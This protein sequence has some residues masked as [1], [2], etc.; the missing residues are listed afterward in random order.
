M[1]SSNSN[2]V[3]SETKEDFKISWNLFKENWKAFLS[4]IF[5]AGV[6]L[7]IVAT[8][9]SIIAFFYPNFFIPVFTRLFS[10]ALTRLI[11][12]LS[13]FIIILIGVFVFFAFLSC[14]YGLAY[15]IMSS[16]DMFAEFKGSFT[17]FRR[18]WW[19]YSILTF[20]IS[21]GIF[22]LA[23]GGPFFAPEQGAPLPGILMHPP[24]I[25]FDPSIE[26]TKFIITEILKSTLYFCWF[27]IFINT[28]PSIT[29][30][31]HKS[32]NKKSQFNE[33][34]NSF[35]ESFNIFH[36]K[37]KRLFCTWGLFFIIF[38]IP[39][40]TLI[41]TA[42]IIYNPLN[43]S[44]W[45]IIFKISIQMLWIF[46]I[47]VGTPMMALISTRIFNSIEFEAQINNNKNLKNKKI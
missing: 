16:G 26:M 42:N 35:S 46:F 2:K 30:R 12:F 34:K 13:S 20:I 4:T 15:D 41:I 45:L 32:N 25:G 3:L 47:F 23:R 5:F 27:I 14:Q 38:Y 1:T 21:W 18:H 44:V 31:G 37:P 7:L 9:L 36:K 11:T 29:A 22:S 8:L 33:F 6:S 40:N 17:Y 28:L 39:L 24:P 19:Q 43:P 10:N